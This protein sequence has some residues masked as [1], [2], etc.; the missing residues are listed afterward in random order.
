MDYS[1][2]V[3]KMEEE[4]SEP[5]AFGF[6]EYREQIESIGDPQLDFDTVHV[7]GTNGKGSTCNIIYRA[8]REE[9][10]SVGLFTG[11]HL[12]SLVERIEVDGELISKQEFA[13]IFKEIQDVNF[14]MFEYLNAVAFKYYRRKDVDIAVIETGCGGRRDATNAVIPE[15]SVITNVGMDHSHVLG[16]SIKEIARE[17]AGIVKEEV[18][19]VNNTEEPAKEVIEEVADEKG[20]E[21]SR[22]KKRFEVTCKSPLKVSYSGKEFET[23]F[24]GRYQLKN[25]NTAVEALEAMEKYEISDTSIIESLQNLLIPGRMEKV[26]DEPEIVIDG[27]HNLEG[28]EALSKSIN[29]FDT[30]VFGCMR[31]KP[32][33]QMLEKL[34]P[35]TDE[36]ILSQPP[37]EHAWQPEE[38]DIGSEIIRDPLEAVETA[39]GK[40]LVTGSLYMIGEVRREFISGSW[41]I[42]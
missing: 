18:P 22:P 1:E 8:L 4:I 28:I 34:R 27:A 38:S 26:S 35:H 17:K 2:A 14:S 13:D 21:V 3:S 12:G 19:V 36:I 15:V 37:K 20:S 33:G 11:P 30:I 5:E 39:E 41:R 10:Y 6:E 29:N 9:G 23:S 24:E 25:I 16:D 42:Q 40:T 7:A 31:K 32:S